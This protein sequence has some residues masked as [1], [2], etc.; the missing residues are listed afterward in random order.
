MSS[1]YNLICL[2]HDP[3]LILHTEWH[4]GGGGREIAA[5]QLR[6]PAA[7]CDEVRLHADC[8]LVIGRY[9]YPLVEVGYLPDRRYGH[10]QWV[11][12]DWLRL[13]A[14]LAGGDHGEVRLPH[15]WTLDRARRLRGDLAL[16]R[17]PAGTG[18]ESSQV[19][20]DS[21]GQ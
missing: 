3:A 16:N 14:H 7:G 1:T 5:E 19:A 17:L 12:A 6:D 11:D 9:S 10:V 20:P 13:L 21:E 4:S 8:D 2:S 15:W 18:A